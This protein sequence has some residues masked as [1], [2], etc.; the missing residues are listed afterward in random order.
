MKIYRCIYSP[1]EAREMELSGGE[2]TITDAK[3][4]SDIC[5]I[6]TPYEDV[7]T[8]LERLLPSEYYSWSNYNLLWGYDEEGDINNKIDATD[9]VCEIIEKRVQNKLKIERKK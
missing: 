8:Q 4:L 7:K 5:N 2:V 9:F 1:Q 6:I 3:N